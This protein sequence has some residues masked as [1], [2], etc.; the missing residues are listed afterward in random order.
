MLVS[1]TFRNISS[2]CSI[3]RMN[4]LC[5]WR[6]VK[7]TNCRCTFISCDNVCKCYKESLRK[8]VSVVTV[9][10]IVAGSGDLIDDTRCVL[11]A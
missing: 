6:C 5:C 1:A 9:L 7:G 11:W 10:S 2:R 4:I 8:R 3:T